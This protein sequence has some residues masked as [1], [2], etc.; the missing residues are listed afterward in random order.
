V[1]FLKRF[2]PKAS[3]KTLRT[4]FQNVLE[5]EELDTEKLS[6]LDHV[7]NVDSCHI[8]FAD[9][10]TASFFASYFSSSSKRY[11]HTNAESTDPS[12]AFSTAPA[13]EKR[14]IEAEVISGTPEII[15]WTKVPLSARKAYSEGKKIDM[16]EDS[17][18]EVAVEG[19]DGD[20]KAEKDEGADQAPIDEQE[21][22]GTSS[23]QADAES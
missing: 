18:Q 4:L 9:A 17:R 3:L 8:R 14:C 16:E 20:A 22:S 12:E 15:Y 7:R 23:M 1:V 6:Y 19:A 11:L 13:D 21:V 2:H 10:S 5:T